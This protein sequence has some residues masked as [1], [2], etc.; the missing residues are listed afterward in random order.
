ML[1]IRNLSG[2][3]DVAE[4]K[5]LFTEA[6]HIIASAGMTLSKWTSNKCEIF[7]PGESS[8]NFESDYSKVLGLV[9]NPSKDVYSFVGVE[10]PEHI[11]PTKRAILAFVARCYD[12]LGYVA[13]FVANLKFLLQELWRLG[14]SWDEPLSSEISRV[15]EGWLV[16]L[17]P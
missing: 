14:L 6:S 2:A 16:G 4:A 12:P 11:V 17:T 5:H 7:H 13:P 8:E 3:D 1:M 9:W 15:V 10:L